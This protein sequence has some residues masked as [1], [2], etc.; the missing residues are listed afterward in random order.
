[1]NSTNTVSNAPKG[2]GTGLTNIDKAVVTLLCL[3][4]LVAPVAGG[5][6]ATP[7]EGVISLPTNILG[8]IAAFGVDLIGV[9]VSVALV[10]CVWKEFKS[11]QEIGAI[12]NLVTCTCLLAALATLS[13][14]P[15][16]VLADSFNELVLLYSGL[17]VT[18][19][20]ARYCWNRDAM[21]A[22]LCSIV[23]GAGIEGALGLRE[24]LLAYKQ[25][26]PDYRIF[27]TFVNPDF[28]AGYLLLTLPLTLVLFAG[29][30][31]RLGKLCFGI[32]LML[33]T[34]ALMFT[35][36]RAG[37]G[38]G[39]IE[40]PFL[41]LILWSSGILKHS[42]KKLAIGLA[43]VCAA[44]IPSALPLIGRQIS[45]GAVRAAHA[46]KLKAAPVMQTHSL[47]YRIYTWRGT[48]RM[49]EHHPFLGAGIGTFPDTYPRY[50][51]TAFTA[52]AHN[53][54][55]QW[56]SETGFPSLIVLLLL[57]ASIAAFTSNALRIRKIALSA[58]DTSDS[59]A[60]YHQLISEPSLI[61]CGLLAAL[62]G[63]VVK[64]LIDSDWY[65]VSTLITLAAVLGV[66]LGL[67]RQIAPLTT[68]H[69]ARLKPA[70]QYGL[71]A[72]ALITLIRS[73]EVAVATYYRTQ[74]SALVES[75]NFSAIDQ[76]KSAAQTDPLNP[77][78]WLTLS[79]LQLSVGDAAGAKES[80]LQAVH[81]ANT[82]KTWYRLGQY[83][84]A[85]NH[86][87]R[88]LNAFQN[89]LQCDPHNLQ[90]LHQLAT[91]CLKAGNTNGADGYYTRMAK[92]EKQPY[93]TVRA[94]ADQIVEV[95]YAYAHAGLADI[96]LQQ[97]NYAKAN[98]EYQQAAGTLR[99]YWQWRNNPEELASLP[100]ER[101]TSLYHLYLHVLASWATTLQNLHA[102]PSQITA[103]SQEANT[104]TADRIADQ[105]KNTKQ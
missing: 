22:L 101:R 23:G 91:T 49:A 104:V 43:L 11:P 83:Y 67:A 46:P 39:F 47:L 56:T 105:S 103:L 66:M 93:G 90:T 33:Q 30:K 65:I 84:E 29:C 50:A 48:V 8:W 20:S 60:P 36:S 99:L 82:G 77:D 79:S 42:A 19:L 64:T 37:I 88:A 97:G 18:W 73:G 54:L 16:P 74:A 28:L 72:A 6:F 85:R 94:I 89:A 40:L 63:S 34:S 15:S 68:K 70:A 92:L 24:Y 52:H 35:G 9:L 80:L 86:L 59:L 58:G 81:V 14:I 7:I 95:E 62:I 98:S 4:L 55:L 61:V 1:M 10:L 102:P 21:T 45:L 32:A 27:G 12:P 2:A 25:H 3:A 44:G 76:L 17:S 13:C 5:S 38:A 78:N 57:L 71:L 31:E 51:I 69:P 96:A 26:E 53:S 41:V 75:G 87:K 100:A